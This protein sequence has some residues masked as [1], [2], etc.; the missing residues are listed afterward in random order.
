MSKRFF[1][2]S[3]FAAASAI[4]LILLPEKDVEE[5]DF[6]LPAH[7]IIRN[8]GDESGSHKKF[9]AW[10]EY[11]HRCAP[12]VN[13][14]KMDDETRQQKYAE[15]SKNKSIFNPSTQ[16]VLAN[17]NLTGQWNERGSANCA[18]RIWAADLDTSNGAVYCGS[19]GGNVWK[20][21]MNGSSW[22]VLNDKLKFDI[23]MIRVVPN[24]SGK[25]VITSGGRYVYYTDDDGQ[26]W[27]TA[28]GLSNLAL[29][30]YVKKGIVMD[31]S[32][33]TMY[34]LVYEWDYAN[35]NGVTSLYKSVDK[36]G[37]FSLIR[38]YD[39]PTFGSADEFD[40][41]TTRYRVFDLDFIHSD[42]LF[43]VGRTNDTITFVSNPPLISNG[44]TILT[45]YR[46]STTNYLYAYVDQLIYR[47]LDGGQ[48]WNSPMGLGLNPF[49]SS[50]FSCSVTNPNNIYF[51]DI[52]C[53][54]STDGGNNWNIVNNWWDYYP[55]VPN[56]LHADL[57]GVYPLL[58]ANGNEFWFI[59]T[60]GGL[61]KS[62]NNLQTVQ[63]LSLNGLNV[64]Q[65][66]SVYTNS[67]NTNYVY[68]GSQDQG[69]QRC[70][71]DSNTVLG[72][73]QVVS[74]DYGHICSSDGGN[75]IWMN[76]PGF[77]DFYAN[78][79]TGSSS[80]NWTFNSTIPFWIPPMMVDRAVNNVCYLAG[81][82]LNTTGSK[83][84]QLVENSGVINAYEL[85][86]N[87]KTASGGGNI[88]A[89]AS[90]P[91]SDNYWYVLTDNGRFFRSTDYGSTWTMTTTAGLGANYL[92]GATIYP[93]QTTLGVVYIGG[94]GYS[95]PPAYRTSNHGQNF[96]AIATGIPSTHIF[97][98]CG[99]YNDSLIFA[100]TEVGPYVY[101]VA[102]SQWYD[103]Q[104]AGAPD[105][106][107]WGVEYIQSLNTVRFCTYGRGIWDFAITSPSGGNEIALL[108]TDLSLYPNPASENFTLNF[109]AEDNSAAE[110]SIYSA[111]GGL[112]QQKS[113]SVTSGENSLPVDCAK[114][115]EGV[116]FISLTQNDRKY[117]RKLL[118][119][120]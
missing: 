86:F 77:T 55:N 35:W 87:F 88:S 49:G 11:M 110:L 104:G 93:S 15:R 108:E 68:A 74:G 116:Y 111:S 98:L 73:T 72:F 113:L 37:S 62:Y 120:H 66:Y 51:G 48:T 14:R 95:N 33:N 64:S 60:D 27:D 65:Y 114:L 1:I 112:V 57:P 69:F 6:P 4:T 23:K 32:L 43:S 109:I 102:D 67:N 38:S 21:D 63:N 70:Q 100:A 76:Y 97:E 26:T 10:Y 103:M 45:G 99:N 94:S 119:N 3:C 24:G 31:D 44:Y 118:V 20:G 117:I 56:R 29:W 92:Y 106:T 101:V 2:F 8:E 107:Y 12:G 41:W 46:D 79:M 105:Q 54:Y 25:R 17:G 83:I 34:I 90:S 18:G 19:D 75:S 81:G 39:E 61:Y 13:W 80:A 115:A 84:I 16:E 78:G 96:T 36:A 47:S 59:C 52:E 40:I 58:D 22:T 7:T 89:I 71:N 85:P 91:L 28:S 5:T 82:N 50:S 42:S 9:E 30:G 53:H